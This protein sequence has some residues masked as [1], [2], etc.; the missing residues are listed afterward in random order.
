MSAPR[1][2]SLPT[3]NLDHLPAVVENEG[4]QSRTKLGERW[5]KRSRK[6]GYAGRGLPRA[7]PIM[8][9]G[10][11]SS[12][13]ASLARGTY[14]PLLHLGRR[15]DTPPHRGYI[16][17]KTHIGSTSIPPIPTSYAHVPA[18]RRSEWTTT[19]AC[20]YERGRQDM[21]SDA[22]ACRL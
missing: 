7:V 12:V 17:A 4:Y 8:G 10:E 1:T 18:G 5:R 14:L 16:R 19:G 6:K 13:E 20:A 2:R 11:P 15:M 22:S 21:L 3:L 9:G